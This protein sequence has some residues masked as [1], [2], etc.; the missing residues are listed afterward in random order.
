MTFFSLKAFCTSSVFTTNF[1]NALQFA[2][3]SAVK[4]TKTGFPC[5]RASAMRL[6]IS[7][8]EVAPHYRDRHNAP[9]ENRMGDGSH[10]PRGE[11]EDQQIPAQVHRG[12]RTAA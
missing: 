11:T 4:S 10:R 2:H 12:S 7:D 6:P 5:C 8:R 1:S 9:A 3:Q